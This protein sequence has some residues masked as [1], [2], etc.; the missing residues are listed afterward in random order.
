MVAL[1]GLATTAYQQTEKQKALAA[2]LNN[3]QA[4][5]QGI[6]LDSLSTQPADLENQLS[7]I[8]PEY[9]QVKAKFER[10]F[11]STTITSAL[12]Q[13]AE[14]KGLAITAMTSSSP[15]IEKLEGVNLST[16]TLTAVVQ[17]NAANLVNYIVELNSLLKTSTVKS[18]EI[19]VPST[20]G[21]D[22]T[23]ITGDNVTPLHIVGENATAKIEMSVYSYRGE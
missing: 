16:I 19:S 2:Q 10:Q 20:D 11:N 21:T 18:V 4:K 23:Q 3:S 12:F 17:G 8:T 22:V 13:M 15:T 6:H 9:E 14:S 5:L 7:Q 1:A